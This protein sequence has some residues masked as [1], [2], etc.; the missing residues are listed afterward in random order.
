MNT[1]SDKHVFKVSLGL[2]FVIF[3]L[4]VL[5]SCSRINLDDNE[6][7]VIS[8][9]S[10]TNKITVISSNSVSKQTTSTPY[11]S[12]SPK[13]TPVFEPPTI[14]LPTPIIKLGTPTPL[15]G[16][17]IQRLLRS[18]EL[19]TSALRDL[20]KKKSFNLELIDREKL[21]DVLIEIFEEDR[22][23]INNNEA[24]YRAMGII[25]PQNSLIELLLSLYT[26][27]GLGLY[28]WEDNTVYLVVDTEKFEPVNERTYVHEFVHVLQQQHFDIQSIYESVKDNSDAVL[29][30]R[31]LVEGDARMTELNYLYQNMTIEERQQ[32]EGAPDPGLVEVFRSAPYVVQREY[33]FPYREGGDF[34]ASLYRD[35]GWQSIDAVF[36]NMPQ[37]TE[38]ILHPEKYI[39]DESPIVVYLPDFLEKLGPGWVIVQKDTLGELFLQSYL[40]TGGAID[41]GREAAAGWGGDSYVLL[42]NIDGSG[43]LVISVVWDTLNDAIEFYDLFLSLTQNRTGGKFESRGENSNIARLFLDQEVSIAVKLKD[44]ETT[45]IFSPSNQVFDTVISFFE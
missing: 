36:S 11:I 32:S 42:K 22:Q 6:L 35:F 27:G 1:I 25:S 43:L 26:V 8:T 39:N 24:L 9:P 14:I 33:V 29:A 23:K 3:H 21:R 34:V 2:V 44:K 10:L 12:K 16:D 45:I 17:R 31:A 18:V 5:F 19:R 37:S 30:F 13:P 28:R 40:M 41:E 7:K 20:S 38:Q 4:G 15:P